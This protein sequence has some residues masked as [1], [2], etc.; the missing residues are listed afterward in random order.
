MTETKAPVGGSFFSSVKK[1]R[2]ALAARSHETYEK[3]IKIID[4]AAAAGDF[5]TAAK[6]TWMLLE[7]APK[8]E[9]VSIIDSS[10]AKAPAQLD[11]G[12]RGP[13]I[14]I[15][16]KVGGAGN[17]PALPAPIVIDA[18]PSSD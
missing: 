9:G 17:Q 3:L 6:Y 14:Q 8:E 4:M 12:P 11:S 13:V 7:H 18:E 1:A 5:E 2:A 15:G 10:A 16:V